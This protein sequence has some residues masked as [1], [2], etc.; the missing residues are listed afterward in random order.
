MDDYRGGLGDF[1][2]TERYG[3]VYYDP[4]VLSSVD[5]ENEATLEGQ[6]LKEKQEAEQKY[7]EHD[8]RIKA[9][10]AEA[11]LSPRKKRK[12]AAFVKNYAQIREKYIH[13]WRPREKKL[14]KRWR[15]R[16]ILSSFSEPYC[17]SFESRR[18]AEESIAIHTHDLEAL[19]R[20]V[21]QGEEEKYKF[22]WTYY[23]QKLAATATYY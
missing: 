13:N 11:E 4:D 1:C 22:L 8:E 19:H 10:L 5:Y 6:L 15:Y 3:G 20:A 17:E 14:K 7:R 2:G 12:A 18:A 9:L 21:A 23:Q 16:A